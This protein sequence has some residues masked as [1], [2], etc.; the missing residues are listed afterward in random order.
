M[1]WPST[2]VCYVAPHVVALRRMDNA[3]LQFHMLRSAAR[4]QRRQERAARRMAAGRSKARLGRR[5]RKRRARSRR[6]P[7]FQVM[8]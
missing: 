5:E 3:E 1:S 8:R 4:S 6:L 2:S 7:F